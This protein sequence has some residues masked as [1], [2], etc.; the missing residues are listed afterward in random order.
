VQYSISISL[1]ISAIV[2]T[3]ASDRGK[4]PGKGYR[5]AWWLEIGF[6]VVE[7]IVVIFSVCDSRFDPK[8][9]RSKSFEG[10]LGFN[11]RSN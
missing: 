1:G 2:E 10:Q 6:A 8:K 11:F 7:F 5:E 9:D 3:Y 4:N